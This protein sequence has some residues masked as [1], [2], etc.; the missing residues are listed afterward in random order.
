M[1]ISLNWLR[2]FIDLPEPPEVISDTLTMLGLEVEG[3]ETSERLP[4]GLPGVVIGQVQ[5]C[6]QHPNADRLKVCRVD[7]GAPEPVQIVCGAPNVAAGQ[8]VPV[9]T[10]G[11]S[12][13][14][15]A[16]KSL[17]IKRSKLRGEVSEGM[18][19]AEDEL[20]IG[21]NHDGIMVLDT[22]LPIGTPVVNLL[23]NEQDTVFEI[24][25]TPNRTDAMSH[26]GVARDLA[27]KFNRNLNTL[28]SLAALDS[29]PASGPLT[30][31]V[32][33][34]NT[35]PDYYGLV[36]EDVKVGE[37]PAWL[38]QRLRSIGQRPI[39][40]VVDVTNYVLHSIGQPL[41][42]FD[43][44]AIRGQEVQV[45]SANQGE[46]LTTLDGVE[47]ELTGEE[48]VIADAEAPMCLAGVMGGLSTGTTERTT[49][50]FLE[51]AYFHP[52][53]VRA[54]VKRQG[55]HS[56]TS[57]RYERG[58]DPTTAKL[59]LAF[60]VSLLKDIAG[61]KPAYLTHLQGITPQ[62]AIIVHDFDY[63]RNLLGVAISDADQ[64]DLLHR[65]GFEELQ[66]SGNKTTIR[67]Q[68]PPYRTDVYRP[69]DV[70][71]E[72]LRVFGLNEVTAPS[73]ITATPSFVNPHAPHRIQREISKQ[74]VG[75]GLQEWLHNS[76]VSN[77]EATAGAVSMLNP[78][79]QENAV[80]RRS[81]WQTGLASVAHNL[82]RGQERLQAF[83]F[84]KR[85]QQE[86]THYLETQV[87]A[88]WF[89]D[90]QASNSWPES[91][92]LAG[93]FGLR[94]LVERIGAWLRLAIRVQPLRNASD[95]HYGLSVWLNHTE[96]C[97]GQFGRVSPAHLDPFDMTQPV[98]VAELDW[99]ALVS[100][101]PKK[102]VTF[103]ALPKYPSVTRDLSLTLSPDV[104]Y[105]EVEERLLEAGVMEL[106]AAR[107]FD[108][109]PAE[110]DKRYGISLTFQDPSKTLEGSEL[111]AMLQQVI[112]ALQTDKR[113]R[114]N[115]G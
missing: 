96:T 94:Q 98:Y 64:R 9:A 6:E 83:E 35:C 12:L 48:L 62:K 58:I 22:D 26:Y 92:V 20:G 85:Y 93:F 5:S 84:G 43:Y 88:C 24:G 105:Q 76:L 74:L 51:A 31:T 54:T 49:T 109:Y 97:I 41:H 37:S 61:A 33:D 57:F 106:Q 8:K 56:D 103:S 3:M 17:R 14:L 91:R 102:A 101:M 95:F 86:G 53:A 82:N 18:I 110:T 63:I 52:A 104:T 39:N 114:V 15:P 32:L 16:G 113:I 66:D 99:D 10:V 70:A 19:C 2:E 7:I 87:L 100:A 108:V 90:K 4:G 75:L 78:L 68:V 25:L 71:E 36:L 69:Q 107:L 55:I 29:L 50:V 72:I 81:L 1:H 27:A 11:T 42:A 67:L 60:A 112:E 65:L 79:S 23:G 45:R 40:N 28:T 89:T 77:K 30:L 111:E 21:D 44:Q 13:P 115:V 46:S 47:R 38:R 73:R 80:M 34:P 59:G